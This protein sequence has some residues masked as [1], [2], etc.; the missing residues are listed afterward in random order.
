[1]SEKISA[2]NPNHDEPA[3][4]QEQDERDGA[5]SLKGGGLAL[6]FGPLKGAQRFLA[7]VRVEFKKISWPTRQQI[8]TET[9]VVL[10]VVAFLTALITGLD[11]V[12]TEI[13]NRFLV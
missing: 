11:W 8:L 12:F 10:I 3:A 7:E 9:V 5:L 13:S 1:M 4:D 6:S 2:S